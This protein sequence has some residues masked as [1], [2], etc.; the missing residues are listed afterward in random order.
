MGDIKLFSYNFIYNK[1]SNFD[2]GTD[3]QCVIDNLKDDKLSFVDWTES[4]VIL[5]SVFKDDYFIRLSQ[6]ENGYISQMTLNASGQ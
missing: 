1:Y 4:G 3:L 5:G 2:C 6:D